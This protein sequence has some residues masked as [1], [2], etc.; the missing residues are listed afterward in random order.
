[1]TG[2]DLSNTKQSKQIFDLK[3]SLEKIGWKIIEE[4][5]RQFKGKP[6]WEINDEVPNLIYSWKIQRDPAIPSIRLDF[7]AWRDWM[8]YET[9]INN[10]SECRIN[11][12][13]TVLFFNKEKA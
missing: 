12:T 4:I 13:E 2:I 8:T 10:C 7:I 3:Q 9:F 1:M 11:D 5:Q 6:R